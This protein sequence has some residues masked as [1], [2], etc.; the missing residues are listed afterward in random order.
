MIDLLPAGDRE[1]IR[2]HRAFWSWGKNADLLGDRNQQQIFE[3]L[4]CTFAFASVLADRIDGDSTPRFNSEDINWLIT[5]CDSTVW[6]CVQCGNHEGRYLRRYE[7]TPKLRSSLGLHL[8]TYTQ[9]HIFDKQHNI[10]KIVACRDRVETEHLYMGVIK[11]LR[12]RAVTQG[13]HVTMGRRY[14]I[15]SK[16]PKLNNVCKN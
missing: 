13:Y 4:E 1:E 5:V 7:E 14:L 2:L 15:H 9:S 16:T 11:K 12:V 3:T 8:Q 6:I 10:C